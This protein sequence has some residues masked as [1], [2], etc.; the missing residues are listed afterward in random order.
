MTK[1]EMLKV[2]R[3]LM[4]RFTSKDFSDVKISKISSIN[5]SKSTMK[6]IMS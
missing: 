6:S 4:N 3:D 1:I 5:W 2:E